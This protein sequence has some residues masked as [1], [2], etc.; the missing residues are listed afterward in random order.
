M[1]TLSVDDVAKL[2]QPFRQFLMKT[3]MTQ[4]L[5]SDAGRPQRMSRLSTLQ[6]SDAL[7]VRFVDFTQRIDVLRASSKRPEG[8][9]LAM[10]DK[11]LCQERTLLSLMAMTAPTLGDALQVLSRYHLLSQGLLPEPPSR[12]LESGR[13]V[14]RLP[15]MPVRGLADRLVTDAMI[16]LWVAAI[17][18]VS[19]RQSIVET[20]HV[21][22]ARHDVDHD[23]LLRTALKAPVQY[24]STQNAVVLIPGALQLAMPEAAPALHQQ[25]RLL[26][27]FLVSHL[28]QEQTLAMQVNDWLLRNMRGRAPSL[29]Q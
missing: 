8:L 12:Q 22:Y 28:G 21:Q 4:P 1:M 25:L 20:I 2:D 18:Q 26:A 9:G 10:A 29:E 15:A 24:Q 27:D 11:V 3:G 19:P 5:I 23:R 14:L 16:A 17:R 7:P 6:V 13:V